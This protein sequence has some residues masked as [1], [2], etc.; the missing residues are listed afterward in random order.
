MWLLP[1]LPGFPASGW[2]E[3]AE[4]LERARQQPLP[5]SG[6]VAALAEELGQFVEG[7]RLEDDPKH[8]LL[9]ETAQ[10][11]ILDALGVALAATTF[12]DA[13]PGALRAMALASGESEDSSLI[14]L[15]A[16][17]PAPVAALVNGSLIHGCEFDAMH[18]ERIIHPN[19]PAVGAPLAI[20][21]RDGRPGSALAEAWVVAAETT[22]RLAAG[23]NDEESLFSDGF[24]TT[25]IFGTFGAAAGVSKLL[26][27]DAAQTAAALNI[28]VS[29]AAGTSTGWDAPTGRNKPLQPGWAAHGGTIA[30][31]L[32]AGGQG[33]ALDAIDGPRG[34]YA[35][36][37]WRQGWERERVLEGLG[38]EWRSPATSFKV[39]PAGGM[40]QAANDCALELVK[41][42]DI[43][44]GEVQEVEVTVPDQFARV[45]DQVL[46]A[47]YHP[48]SG[49]A[50]FVSWPCNVARAILSRS[51]EFAHLSDSAVSDPELLALAGRWGCRAGQDAATTV[52]ITTSRGAFERRRERHSG[53]PPEMT[54]GRVVEKFRRNAALVLPG[55][56]V[57]ALAE[58]V[59]GLEQLGSVRQLTALL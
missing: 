57:E 22:L 41:E 59:L 20:A 46:E 37:A 39:Y 17:A 19:G 1:P 7:F 35:A 52:T 40:I 14:G 16:R 10:M 55:D 3:G 24:H 31:L 23:L 2:D 36:H 42:H 15:G 47:S 25:A 26:G 18:A 9:V 58:A 38:S 27:L 21:E 44:P 8:D 56:R 50:T 33:C 13:T 54:L 34:F 48:G 49:Y 5:Y 29:F 45:L 6:A 4:R 32:A 51:V 30:A 43:S 28:C 11:H 53:H 12:K